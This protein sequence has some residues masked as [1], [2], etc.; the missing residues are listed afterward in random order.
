[1]IDNNRLRQIAGNLPLRQAFGV[2]NELLGSFVKY[3]TEA[4]TQPSLVN[5]DFADLKAIMERGGISAIGVGEGDGDNRVDIAVNT[6]LDTQ[7]LDIYDME[8]SSGALIHVVGG[9]DMTLEEVN[10]AGELVQARLTPDTK[11]IWGARVDDTMTGH[12]RVMVA[13]TGIE[14]SFLTPKPVSVISSPQPP[15]EEPSIQSPE[16]EEKTQKKKGFFRGLFTF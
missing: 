9:D 11:M 8:K 1:V 6:A 7:L 13:L 4:I 3:V 15:P 16:P 2:A 14:S 5:I 12:I 10:R